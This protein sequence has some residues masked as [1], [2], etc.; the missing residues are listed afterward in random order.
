MSPPE[1]VSR[2]EWLVARKALLVEEK[3]DAVR[4]VEPRGAEMTSGSFYHLDLT[5]LGRQEDWEEPEGR[6]DQV[7]GAGPGFRRLTGCSPARAPRRGLGR[8][9]TAP[10]AQPRAKK[11]FGRDVENRRLAPPLR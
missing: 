9:E 1:I 8:R 10:Q 5:A 4:P 11:N 2:D 3:D 7:R 6:A